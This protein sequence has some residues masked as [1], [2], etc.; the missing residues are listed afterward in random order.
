ML[1]VNRKAVAL[2]HVIIWPVSAFKFA[3][4]GKDSIF[5]LCFFHKY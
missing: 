4:D 2:N 5:V 3:D 1:N